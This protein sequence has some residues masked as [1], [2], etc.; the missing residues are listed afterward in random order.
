MV[1]LVLRFTWPITQLD[2]HD[3]LHYP[4][5]TALYTKHTIKNYEP[6]MQQKKSM[7]PMVAV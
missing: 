5:S 6:E 7:P 2:V 3:S 4:N 1:A